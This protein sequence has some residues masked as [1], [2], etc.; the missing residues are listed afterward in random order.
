MQILICPHCATQVAP[1]RQGLCP[2]CRKRIESVPAEEEPADPEAT[3]EHDEPLEV[4]FSELRRQD[5]FRRE[6]GRALFLHGIFLV[7]VGVVI[8]LV[9][10]LVSNFIPYLN[11]LL[12]I[13]LIPH[14]VASAHRSFVDSRKLRSPNAHLLLEQDRRPPVL[15]LRSFYDDS[16][17]KENRFLEQSARLSPFSAV[18]RRQTYEEQLTEIAQCVGPVVAVGKPGEHLPEVGAARMYLP[19][20]QWQAKVRELLGV[21]GLVILRT[22]DTFGLRWE[23][24]NALKVV[25]PEKLILYME[26]PGCLSQE[27]QGMLPIPLPVR[28]PKARFLFFDPDWTPHSAKSIST[29]L[30]SKA[31]YRIRPRTLALFIAIVILAAF[32][33]WFIVQLIVEASSPLAH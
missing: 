1:T 16:S 9:L 26:P 7:V 24:E 12:G 33:G 21:A 8:V 28:F 6:Q 5:E 25:P 10:N 3:T 18:F 27:F 20:S 19:D 22:G 23:L 11:W 30:K 29:V 13:L 31:L 15:Y 14:I 17:Y 32:T 2:S 4:D